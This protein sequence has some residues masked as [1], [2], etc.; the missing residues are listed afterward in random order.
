MLSDR[1]EALNETETVV[2]NVLV[3]DPK[4]TDIIHESCRRLYIYKSLR[5]IIPT[6]GLKGDLLA[7]CRYYEPCTIHISKTTPL[8][9]AHRL[10]K[11]GMCPL[12]MVMVI[13]DKYN[14]SSNASAQEYDLTL[15][16]SIKYPLRSFKYRKIMRYMLTNPPLPKHGLSTFVPD[17]ALFRHPN[18]EFMD[19]V[20]YINVG[21]IYGHVTPAQQYAES[22]VQSKLNAVFDMM[23]QRRHIDSI[24][25]S[26]MGCDVTMY[27]SAIRR[28][29]TTYMFHVREIVFA[30]SDN[31][32]LST[33]LDSA[34]LREHH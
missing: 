15:Q 34:L 13:D 22:L 29:L 8:T 33:A 10:K 25:F 27:V 5:N 2:Y 30:T 31:D 12:V 28:L 32:T 4:H 19:D 1:R 21:L 24:I 3:K 20:Y 26:D 16:T 9:E 7:N 14:T 11:M 17:V 6:P 18:G 23:L